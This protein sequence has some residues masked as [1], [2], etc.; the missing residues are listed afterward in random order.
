MCVF[1]GL[2]L[3]VWVS[4]SVSPLSLALCSVSAH[5]SALDSSCGSRASV[6][7]QV[8]SESP[9][10]PGSDWFCRLCFSG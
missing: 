3:Y 8:E 4:V 2:G 9:L 7:F 6:C 5:L 1:L 10:V